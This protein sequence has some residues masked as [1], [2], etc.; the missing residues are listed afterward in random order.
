MFHDIRP[1]RPSNSWF[2]VSLVL[3]CLVFGL[4]FL[5]KASLCGF[6]KGPLLAHRVPPVIEGRRGCSSF[7]PLPS[8]ALPLMGTTAG[9]VTCCFGQRGIDGTIHHHTLDTER[10]HDMFETVRERTKVLCSRYVCMGT[11][12]ICFTI[13][14]RHFSL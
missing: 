4:I 9:G 13:T 6:C 3:W 1:A 11:E 14:F 5:S 12:T 2:L 7:P 8:S 10:N